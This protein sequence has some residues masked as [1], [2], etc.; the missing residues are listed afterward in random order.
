MF[1][2]LRYVHFIIYPPPCF[3]CSQTSIGISGYSNV[4]ETAVCF[5]CS[6]CRVKKTA[7]CFTCLN[8]CANRFDGL[9][10]IDI[11]VIAMINK[12]SSQFRIQIKITFPHFDS[13][14]HI[15]RNH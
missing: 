10:T 8:D 12:Q 5:T 4:E 15:V 11:L 6:D 3:I 1:I 9:E 7:V 14:E 13:I 2:S